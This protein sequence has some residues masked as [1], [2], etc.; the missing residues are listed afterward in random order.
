MDWSLLLFAVW[1]F[2]LKKA[3]ITSQSLSSLRRSGNS[4]IP[5]K[6]TRGQTTTRLKQS[7]E[8][9]QTVCKYS[10][11]ADFL[12]SLWP[13][14]LATFVLAHSFFLLPAFWIVE[15]KWPNHLLVY[16]SS[17]HSWFSTWLRAAMWPRS[18]PLA[19][20][21]VSTTLSWWT[22]MIANKKLYAFC[23]LHTEICS[24]LW[25]PCR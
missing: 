17:D 25:W 22:Q 20:I 4:N 14:A 7:L 3:V 8:L 12:V 21:P 9:A 2:C 23:P 19:V 18:Q 6:K 1:P 13:A 5:K 16:R 11:Q 10:L 24:S 15:I